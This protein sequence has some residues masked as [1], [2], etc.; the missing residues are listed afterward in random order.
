MNRAHPNLASIDPAVPAGS[1]E[2]ELLCPACGYDLRGTTGDRC[3][4]CGLA[5]DR[6]AL[7]V[8][9]LPW[10]HRKRSGFW[11]A[12]LRTVR[13]VFR[14]PTLVGR[15][16][17]K[18]QSWPDAV[19]FRRVTTVLIFLALF[20]ATAVGVW[21]AWDQDVTFE[22]VAGSFS[23]ISWSTWPPRPVN[24]WTDFAIVALAG[25]ELWYLGPLY[26]LALSIMWTGLAGYFFHPRSLSVERQNRAAAL[27][28]YT[29][30]PLV[31]LWPMLV[32]GL[33]LAALINKAGRSRQDYEWAVAA[34]GASLVAAIVSIAT[35]AGWWIG[36]LKVMKAATHASGARV[37]WVAV[38]LPVLWVAAVALCLYVL[39]SIVGFFRLVYLSLR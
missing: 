1:G 4:E 18:P 13:M 22:G 26:L 10:S 31:G 29:S 28:C 8:S 33:I 27:S 37:A 32:I 39:P 24:F 14:H 2:A 20:T 15:E 25:L 21:Y 3:T 5:V 23:P 7:A 30:G 36:T 6:A 12:Y 16:A 35:V 11:R 38:A 9:S 19:A 34:Q 17:A